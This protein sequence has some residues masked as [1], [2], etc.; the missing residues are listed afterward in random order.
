M[1][2]YGLS[3]AKASIKNIFKKRKKKKRQ[4]KRKQMNIKKHNEKIN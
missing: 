2:G 3:K 1:K 4:I